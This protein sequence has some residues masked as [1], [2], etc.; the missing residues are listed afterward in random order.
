MV[1][2]WAV[3]CVGVVQLLVSG[4]YREGRG[5]MLGGVVNLA[6]AIWWGFVLI[7]A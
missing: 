5:F 6:I 7:G 4:S 3:I 2:G 1:I